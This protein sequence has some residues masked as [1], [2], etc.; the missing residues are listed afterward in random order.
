M[1]NT[2]TFVMAVVGKYPGLTAVQLSAK[3]DEH[4]PDYGMRIATISNHLTRLAQA[5]KVNRAKN[6]D[7]VFTHTLSASGRNSLREFAEGL[8]E[9]LKLAG[10]AL[11]SL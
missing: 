6:H 11:R 10:E 7:E 5:G 9:G 8:H 3:F 1:N 4:F 2:E